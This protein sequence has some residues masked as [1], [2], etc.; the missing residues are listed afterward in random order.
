MSNRVCCYANE[1]FYDSTAGGYVVAVITENE[2]GYR[3]LEGGYPD[4]LDAKAEA[5]RRNTESGLSWDEVLDIV[6]SSMAAGRVR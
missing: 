1:S 6:A 5:A 2:P 4:V 3:T